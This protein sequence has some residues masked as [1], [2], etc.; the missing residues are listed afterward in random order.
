MID[1]TSFFVLALTT[2]YMLIKD[3]RLIII[4]EKQKSSSLRLLTSGDTSV[5]ERQA[6]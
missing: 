5:E 6:V 4:F 1:A 2:R 3:E